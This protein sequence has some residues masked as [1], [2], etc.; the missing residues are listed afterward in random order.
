MHRINKNILKQKISTKHGTEASKLVSMEGRDAGS[1]FFT[2][3][4][5]WDQFSMEVEKNEI[6][7]NC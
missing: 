3:R 6:L 5:I 1:S 2:V 4:K 7:L